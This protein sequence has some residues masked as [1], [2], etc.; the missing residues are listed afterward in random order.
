MDLKR[1]ERKKSEMQDV[2]HEDHGEQNSRK[3][4]KIE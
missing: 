2:K 4:I 1:H 3:K